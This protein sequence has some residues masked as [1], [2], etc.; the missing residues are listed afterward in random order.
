MFI[1]GVDIGLSKIQEEVE[2]E[3]NKSRRP[4]HLKKKRTQEKPRQNR[5]S[6]SQRRTRGIGSFETSEP[7][8]FSRS[9]AVCLQRSI[10]RDYLQPMAP[11]RPRLAVLGWMYLR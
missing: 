2:K 8:G 9:S 10:R 7:T 6:D 1:Y 5:A 11:M 4:R 3:I